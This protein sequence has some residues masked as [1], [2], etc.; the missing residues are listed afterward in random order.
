MAFQLCHAHKCVAPPDSGSG[1]RPA[2]H[3]AAC[4][5]G[6]P[7]LRGP[8]SPNNRIPPREKRRRN[9]KALPCMKQGSA[10]MRARYAT[11]CPRRK[12]RRMTGVV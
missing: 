1:R 5:Y 8:Q 7:E 3:T 11:S 10:V 4:G 9:E 12:T 6:T 2:K